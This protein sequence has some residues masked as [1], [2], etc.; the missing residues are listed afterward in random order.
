MTCGV[1]TALE[2]TA[3]ATSTLGCCA[4]D[5]TFSPEMYVGTVF[6]PGMSVVVTP[7][8]PV[9]YHDQFENKNR[10]PLAR[11]PGGSLLAF[12][13][14]IIRRDAGTAVGSPYGTTTEPPNPGG[15]PGDSTTPGPHPPSLD[16]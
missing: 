8:D 12:G 3:S 16:Q 10:R 13:I 14:P 6:K 11:R 15:G 1:T 2:A 5:A 4:S 9:F 7:P